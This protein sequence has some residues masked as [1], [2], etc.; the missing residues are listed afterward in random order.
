[1]VSFD[2]L[3]SRDDSY[4]VTEHGSEIECS[5]AAS[6]PSPAKRVHHYLPDLVSQ[7]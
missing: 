2:D 7:L 6:N 1:M 4:T 5:S 3:D